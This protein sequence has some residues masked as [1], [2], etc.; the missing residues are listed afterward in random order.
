M[1][2]LL[3]VFRIRDP[4]PF[5]SR[6]PGWVKIKIRIRDPDHISESLETGFFGLKILKFFDADPGS[7][8]FW[9]GIRDGKNSDPGQ[10]SHIRNFRDMY[11]LIGL[12]ANYYM[13]WRGIFKGLSLDEKWADFSE[14]TTAPLSLMK[15]FRMSLISAGSISLESTFK[16]NKI[17][18]HDMWQ[19]LY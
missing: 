7:G 12:I 13:R 3:E 15:T 11:C 19:S 10:T 1:T 2:V 8:I 16:V 17:P 5:W 14:L 4:I 18:L 6:D 9:S